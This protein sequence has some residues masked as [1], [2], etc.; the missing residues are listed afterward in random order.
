YRVGLHLPRG[1]E[2][3]E[4]VGCDLDLVARLLERLGDLLARRSVG[5][6]H[7]DPLGRPLLPG[8]PSGP[9]LLRLERD[10]AAAVDLA[11][12]DP[13]RVGPRVET[14][15]VGEDGADV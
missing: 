11:V 3:V 4:T 1:D 10:L 13:V 6:D 8:F 15:A 5:V 9:S 12:E 7:E 2:A 14:H